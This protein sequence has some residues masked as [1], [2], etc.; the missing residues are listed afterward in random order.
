MNKK[1]LLE[2]LKNKGI[3]G[4]II[5]AVEKI[6][7]KNFVPEENLKEAYEDH[8]L[9]IG[10]GQT[11]SQPYT[12]A[13]MLEE[14]ELKKGDKVLEIGTGSGWNAALLSYIVGKEGKVY[15]IEIVKELAEQAKEK[16]KDYENVEVFH[17]DGSQGLPEYAPYDKIILTA[18]PK[19]M[20]EEWKKELRDGGILLAP[21]GEYFQKLVKIRKRGSEF[22]YENKGDFVFV[23]LVSYN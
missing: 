15:S 19:E 10:H 3:G 23:P 6:D 21:V 9:P 13:F 7:R 2:E 12:V 17:V 8:P 16:L 18:A 14:L 1:A 11:I 20:T 4:K 5:K 22:I